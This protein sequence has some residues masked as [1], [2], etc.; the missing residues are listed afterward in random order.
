MKQLLTV[1]LLVLVWPTH[2]Q[3]SN[4]DASNH[5]QS[6][7]SQYEQELFKLLSRLNEMTGVPAYS[8]AVVHKGSTVASVS[9]GF[10]NL[11]KKEKSHRES[12]FR[13]ASV[14]KI[15]GATM[16]AELAMEGKLKPDAPIGEYLPQLDRKYHPISTRQLLAHISGMPHYQAKDYDLYK[17]HY[18]S[19]IEALSTLKGRNLLSSPGEKYHYSSHGYTLAG[20]VQESISTMSLS[21]SLPAFVARWTGRKTPIIEDIRNL[22][23]NTSKLYSLSSSGASEEEF[24]EKSYSVF[25]AGLSATAAD[26]AQFGYQVIDRSHRNPALKALLFSPTYTT[27]GTAVGTAKYQLGFGWRMGEDF[28]GRKVYHHAGS[29]PGARSILVLYPEEALSIAILS[30]ASWVSAID[31]MAYSLASLY[32]DSAKARDLKSQA[33]YKASFDESNGSGEIKCTDDQCYLANESTSFTR[34][35]N[36]FNANGKPVTDWP[37]YAYSSE[38]G[39]RLLMVNKVGIRTLLANGDADHYSSTIGKSKTYTIQLIPQQ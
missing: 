17:R 10:T 30:N 23:P 15:I 33:R 13:L 29:T 2:A 35:L 32:L 7:R 28:Q 1:L 9:S 11:E 36:K 6:Q 21:E 27:A 38:R 19:A 4:G 12:I 24:G 34:W 5:E 37:I 22:A 20:A 26:L 16:L 14:S 25:G 3:A 8:V 39:D 31:E 18:D